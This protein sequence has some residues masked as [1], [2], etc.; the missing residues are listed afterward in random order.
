MRGKLPHVIHSPF[1]FYPLFERDAAVIMRNPAVQFQ[2]QPLPDVVYRIVKP[3]VVMGPVVRRMCGA[4][5]CDVVCE[6][7]SVTPTT[8]SGLHTCTYYV[9]QNLVTANVIAHHRFRARQRY[10]YESLLIHVGSRVLKRSGAA[11]TVVG[12]NRKSVRVVS[13]DGQLITWRTCSIVE[14]A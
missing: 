1:G 7:R 8:P 6:M 5:P 10:P 2:G 4:G 13:D 9:Q 12:L 3:S 11:G 14:I